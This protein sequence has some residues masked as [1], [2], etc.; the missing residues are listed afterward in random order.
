MKI[1]IQ[2]FKGVSPKTNPRY[3][4]DGGAQVALNVEAFGQS[5]KPMKGLGEA[6]IGPNL[7]PEAKTVY[8]AGLNSDNDTLYWLSWPTDVDVCRAQIAGDTEEWHFWTGDLTPGDYLKAGCG[9]LTT[10]GKPQPWPGDNHIRLGLP[11]PVNKPLGAVEYADADKYPAKLVLT[12][13]IL[14]EFVTFNFQEQKCEVQ[15]ALDKDANGYRWYYP[16]TI[17]MSLMTNPTITLTNTQLL[18]FSKTYGL[19]LSLDNEINVTKIDLSA[20]E[21]SQTNPAIQVAGAVNAQAKIKGQQF[22]TAEVVDTTSVK[23]TANAA[24]GKIRFVA[25]WGT[26]DNTQRTV[27]LGTPLSAKAVESSFKGTWAYTKDPKVT[28]TG[29]T[30]LKLTVDGS[31]LIVETKAPYVGGGYCSIPPWDTKE[32]CE[33]AKGTWTEA[34]FLALR[35]GPET[36]QQLVAYG[37]TEDKGTLTSHVYFYT[38]VSIPGKDID[39]T[40]YGLTMESAPSPASEQVNLY[41]DSRVFLRVFNDP[42]GTG[43][44]AAVFPDGS[45]VLGAGNRRYLQLSDGRKIHGIR[46]YRAVSG[47]YLLVEDETVLSIDKLVTIDPALEDANGTANYCYADDKDADELGEACPSLL[48][49]EPPA[50]LRGLINLPNGMMAGFVSR[51]LYLCEPYRPYAWPESYINTLDYKIVGLGRMDTTLAV[52]TEGA[53]YFLQGSSPETMVVVKSDI[54]QSCVAKRSIVSMGGIVLYASPDGLIMLRPGGSD[55]LTDG[56]FDRTTWQDLLGTSPETTFHAYGHDG[57]YIAFHR[58]ITDTRVT[59]SVTYTGFLV[60][61]RS[62]QFVRHSFT[63]DCAY[64]DPVNDALYLAISGVLKKWGDGGYVTTGRW[65]SKVFALPQISGFAC[66]QVEAEAYDANLQCRIYRDTT[67]VKT[68]LTNDAPGVLT[69]ARYHGRYPFRL[70][71]KQGRDWEIDLAVTQE[72]FNVV[73]AQSMSEIAQS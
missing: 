53:P 11:A 64:A 12:P 3:L 54:E 48:W 65:R 63:C 38:W 18:A 34:A 71:A 52:L 6:L 10:E 69:N 15:G 56:V 46:L 27:V 20:L 22:V 70:E 24:G 62:K 36:Y 9:A 39:G 49:S 31:N 67:K 58:S 26:D 42:D 35:W 60:D 55:I 4:D 2:S 5:V 66:A 8:R 45:Q 73:L 29:T 41:S 33:K 40:G 16:T 25:R 7:E 17:D 28:V 21:L 50:A 44:L 23:L 14:A 43:T 61:L 72:V 13:L 19:K 68:E 37:S 57:K 47:V 1:S 51:D 30:H 59:P 32:A